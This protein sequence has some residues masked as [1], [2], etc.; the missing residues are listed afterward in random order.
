MEK[1]VA[2]ADFAE[3]VVL[4]GFGD[5][6]IVEIADGEGAV[7][8]DEHAVIHFGRVVLGAADVEILFLGIDDDF[9]SLAHLGFVQFEGNLFLKAHDFI[10]P[11]VFFGLANRVAQLVGWRVILL[12]VSED[13]Q[14]VEA[15][16]FDELHKFLVLFTG[17]RRVAGDKGGAQGD[18]GNGLADAF[19]HIIYIGC[20][21]ATSHT[22]EDFVVDVLDGDVQIVAELRVFFHHIQDFEGEVERV[23]VVQTEP[24]D[25]FHLGE[26]LHQGGQFPFARQIDAVVGQILGDKHYLLDTL[27]GEFLCFFHQQRNRFGDLLVANQ[28][29][30][31][32]GT[33]VVAALRNLEV[34]V[35]SRRGKQTLGGAQQLEILAFHELGQFFESEDAV[36]FGKRLLQFGLAALCEAAH[37]KDFLHLA[38]LFAFQLLQNLIDGLFAR[39]ADETTRVQNHQV[40]FHRSFKKDAVTLLLQLGGDNF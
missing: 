37:N 17:F 39:V 14:S 25:T 36:D 30:G 38:A 23:G 12:R 34:G 22:L 10:L 11:F 19:Y 24:F 3:D 8:A 5:L 21:S 4:G 9:E 15:R 31:A 6:D 7:F 40:A 32:V 16:S 13:A 18:V 29:D 33:L 1:N 2:L 35:V 28:R 20:A 26:S 27:L